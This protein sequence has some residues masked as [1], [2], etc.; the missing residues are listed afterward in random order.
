MR[1]LPGARG[2]VKSVLHMPTK[3]LAETRRTAITPRL[4]EKVTGQRVAVVGA[5]KVQTF[6]P[7]DISQVVELHKRVFPESSFSP[8]ELGIYFRRVFFENPWYDAAIPSLVYRECGGRILGFYGVMPRRM[9]MK[10]RPIRVALSSQFMVD[11]STPNRLAAVELQRAFFAGPQDLSFTDGANDASRKIWEGMGGFTAFSYS[12]HWTRILRPYRYSLDRASQYGLPKPWHRLFQPLCAAGDLAATRMRCS[13][14]HQAG[15][16][17]EEDFGFETILERLP[18]FFG[19][20]QLCPEYDQSSLIWLL[21][22]A[23][24]KQ[25]HGSLRKSLVRGN[26]GRVLG[27]YIYYLNSGGVSQVLQIVAA[28]GSVHSVLDQLFHHAWRLGSFA[29]TGRMD[30]RFLAEWSG[31]RCV[32][33]LNG[34]WLLAHSRHADVREAIQRGDA[35]LT[36]VEGEWWM[37]FHGG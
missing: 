30:P 7:E 14:F 20:S 35:F 13:P 22:E 3:I 31:E 28:R 2:R 1:K 5:G 12:M 8:E 18:S 21:R 37:R 16:A 4:S 32:F 17:P 19:R 6:A 27:W 23:A 33:S 29:V 34:P 9:K 26:E 15:Q 25:C 11:P 24:Q 36:R 10:E